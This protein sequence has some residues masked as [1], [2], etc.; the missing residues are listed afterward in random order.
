M[1]ENCVEGNINSLNTI[2]ELYSVVLLR[3]GRGAIRQRK[4]E[5]QEP[6]FSILRALKS[7]MAFFKD[8]RL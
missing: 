6:Y 1:Q 7:V 2:Y 5:R 4:W 8:V 3:K